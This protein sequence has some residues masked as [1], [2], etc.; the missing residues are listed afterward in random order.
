[1][2]RA[3]RGIIFETTVCKVNRC[4]SKVIDASSVPIGVL[5]LRYIMEERLLIVARLCNNLEEVVHVR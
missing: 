1:M 2:G 3:F 4:Q 5:N